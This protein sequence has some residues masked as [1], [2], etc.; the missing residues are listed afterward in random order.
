MHA[1]Y[2]RHVSCG[3]EVMNNDKSFSKVG[4]KSVKVVNSKFMV[5]SERSGQKEHMPNTGQ[6]KKGYKI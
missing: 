6:Q 3:M 2:E 4:Q 5:L 1:K